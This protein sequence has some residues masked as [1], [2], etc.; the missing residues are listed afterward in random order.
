[1]GNLLS[2]GDTGV[3]VRLGSDRDNYSSARFRSVLCKMVH[4]MSCTLVP[5]L[6]GTAYFGL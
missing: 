5:G 3:W 6:D 4:W 2:T 1:M